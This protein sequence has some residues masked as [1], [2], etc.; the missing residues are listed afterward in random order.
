[1]RLPA[2]AENK[3]A[4]L[5]NTSACGNIST[6]CA[7]R[8]PSPKPRRRSPTSAALPNG[9]DSPARRSSRS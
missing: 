2:L 3:T 5:L 8:S 6:R 9:A 1:M 7:T 4:E